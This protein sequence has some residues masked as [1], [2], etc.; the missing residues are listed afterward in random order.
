[1]YQILDVIGPPK[2]FMHI[3]INKYIEM[4]ICATVHGFQP[5]Q[6]FLFIYLF[7]LAFLSLFLRILVLLSTYW[8]KTFFI[9][10]S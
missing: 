7:I 4:S 5:R 8:L 6:G 9:H 3:S 2:D 10:F 1:M